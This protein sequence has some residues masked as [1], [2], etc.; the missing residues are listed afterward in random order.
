MVAVTLQCLLPFCVTLTLLFNVWH[1]QGFVLVLAHRP[2]HSLYLSISHTLSP[3]FFLSLFLTHTHT[4][5]LTLSLTHTLAHP[6]SLYRS[7]SHPL[8]LSL[9]PPSLSIA[10]FHTH[11][12]SDG[13]RVN[14]RVLVWFR[15]P[16]LCRRD[17]TRA[18]TQ[19]CRLRILGPR[20]KTSRWAPPHKGLPSL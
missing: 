15:N 14:P 13:R 18:C 5:S 8:S 3:S 16:G 9:S 11:S 7:L 1:V 4:H 20:E 10:L 6:L 12:R 17:P 19:G 2:M